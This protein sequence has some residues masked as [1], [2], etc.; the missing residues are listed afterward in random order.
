MT[1]AITRKRGS[2]L[3]STWTGRDAMLIPQD[4]ERQAIPL[5]LDPEVLA[6]FCSDIR[7]GRRGAKIKC[8]MK[9][10]DINLFN[11]NWREQNIA[12]GLCY[13][14][15]KPR[16]PGSVRFCPEHLEKERQRDQRRDR[17]RVRI[18]PDRTRYYRDRRLRL[19]GA[20]A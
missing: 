7:D 14:C 16:D 5:Q 17:D 6:L 8:E 15:S 11:K 10:R 20:L 13:T 4:V 3:V 9:G 2:T 1:Y 12:A 18:R 19:K